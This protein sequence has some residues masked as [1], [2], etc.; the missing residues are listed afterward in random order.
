MVHLLWWCVDHGYGGRMMGPTYRTAASPHGHI[1][2]STPLGV[3]RCG[4]SMGQVV[5]GTG[6]RGRPSPTATEAP[7]RSPPSHLHILPSCRAHHVRK[8]RQRQPMLDHLAVVEQTGE[9]AV[10]S[11][12][13]RHRDR[14]RR[15]VMLESRTIQSARSAV[16]QRVVQVVDQRYFIFCDVHGARRNSLSLIVAMTATVTVYRVVNV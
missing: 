6:Q 9:V 1:S 11:V 7:A 14:V 2:K 15:C 5:L 12:L 10:R 8:P 13:H 3:L 4:L 16:W